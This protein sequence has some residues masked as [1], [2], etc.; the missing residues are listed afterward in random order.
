M[1][2][3]AD[4]RFTF[5]I[6]KQLS[7]QIHPEPIAALRQWLDLL[8]PLQTRIGFIHLQLSEFNRLADPEQFFEF[9]QE[10]RKFSACC[11]EVRHPHFFDKAQHEQTLHQLLRTAQCERMVFDSRALFSQPATTEALVD[12]QAKKPK[13]PVHVVALTSQPAF[14]FIGVDDMAVNR[15]FYQPWL[16]KMQQWLQEGKTPYAFFHTPDNQFCTA[17]VS[18][19]CRRS[20]GIVRRAACHSRPLAIDTVALASHAVLIATGDNRP[21]NRV[22]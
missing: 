2:T 9:L 6:P 16:L 18:A 13:L 1:Q 12:A 15:Q 19:I 11:V 14:R 8:K 4:F 21:A 5:K 20:R 10:I 22:K 7:H 3:P 17:I